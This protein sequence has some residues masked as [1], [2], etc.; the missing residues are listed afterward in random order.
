MRGPTPFHPC[1]SSDDKRTPPPPPPKKKKTGK[2]FATAQNSGAVLS[3]VIV[4]LHCSYPF[5]VSG[6]SPYRTWPVG[7]NVL[8]YA[9][10]PTTRR[11]EDPATC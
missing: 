8:C 5:Y 3:F 7:R 4:Y 2:E 10:G 1:S 11:E 9:N 6:V